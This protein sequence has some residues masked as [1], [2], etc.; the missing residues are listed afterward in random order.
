MKNSWGS[1]WGESGYMHIGW[2]VSNIGYGASYIV[3]S[4][5]PTITPSPSPVPTWNDDFSLAIDL[6]LS[7]TL[8]STTL[9]HHQCH[10]FL[11]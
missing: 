5:E 2:G 6:P 7:S 10:H 4:N 3:Y 8:Y 1:W 9:K 11:G